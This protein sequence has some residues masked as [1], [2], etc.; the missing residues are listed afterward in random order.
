LPALCLAA[1]IGLLLTAGCATA[2]YA[3]L[4]MQDRSSVKKL[5]FIMTEQGPQDR[6][7]YEYGDDGAERRVKGGDAALY[8]DQLA[9]VRENL[10]VVLPVNERCSETQ[11]THISMYV[12]IFGSI[13][14]VGLNDPETL[15]L[16]ERES[17]KGFPA[18][19]EA[20]HDRM[21]HEGCDA[22]LYIRIV[23]LVDVRGLY[24]GFFS[25]LLRP[26][27]PDPVAYKRI[28]YSEATPVTLDARE[29]FREKYTRSYR[30]FTQ[31]ALRTLLID[32]TGGPGV[33]Q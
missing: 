24:T 22:V 4:S 9:Y 6:A 2:R 30:A 16:W 31:D 14:V 8:E 33:E 7:V 26:G 1:S 5:L 28:R 29:D 32:V 10:D 27:R 12:S 23:H 13:P 20:V 11:Y 3:P 25:Y 17:R 15:R 18:A 19:L 21:T